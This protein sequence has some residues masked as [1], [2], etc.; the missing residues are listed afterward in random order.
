MRGEKGSE[1]ILAQSTLGGISIQHGARTL[2]RTTSR[3]DGGLL[4]LHM[5]ILLYI[6]CTYVLL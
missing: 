3:I 2:E 1:Y 5:C 6:Y 4:I